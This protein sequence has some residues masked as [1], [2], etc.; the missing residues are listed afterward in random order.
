MYRRLILGSLFVA[1]ALAAGRYYILARG[2]K[3][4]G[5]AQKAFETISQALEDESDK[6]ESEKQVEALRK[7]YSGKFLEHAKAYPGDGTACK[8]LVMVL[9]LSAKDASQRKAAVEGLRKDFLKSEF[10]KSHLKDLGNNPTD[11]ATLDL[12]R[13]VL[14]EHPDKEAQALACKT[15]IKSGENAL[16]LIG[17]AKSNEKVRARAESFLGKEALAKFLEAEPNF[18]KEVKAL[19]EKM[20]EDFKG[21]LPDASVGSDAPPLEAED[22]DGK[23]VRLSDLKGK[24]VVVD[25]WATWCGPCRAMIP[26]NRE[27]VK[28]LKDRPFVFVS[29][30]V[31]KERDAVIEFRKKTEMP[32]THWWI[33]PGAKALETWEVEGFPTV[34]VIDHKGVIRFSESGFDENSKLGEEAE[35]LTKAAEKKEK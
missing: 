18:E 5:K 26:N 4:S 15:L 17:K 6:V 13:D 22:L 29:V 32:W 21:L 7:K 24:V 28:K 3:G 31:D 34:Y 11:P 20:R 1:A 16:E 33:G 23:K 30:S 12:L 19:K 8:A 10:I 35:K 2:D 27:L 14:K 9:R 25:F